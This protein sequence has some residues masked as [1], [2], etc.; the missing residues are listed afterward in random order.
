MKRLT[1]VWS[2]TLQRLASDAHQADANVV[3]PLDHG[4]AGKLWSW[5]V[6]TGKLSRNS[7]GRDGY[8]VHVE[9]TYRGSYFVIEDRKTFER[10]HHESVPAGY[11]FVLIA[12]YL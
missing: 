7:E 4:S 5:A 8:G 3:K 12:S 6:S 1:S 9:F 10:D 2:R 11:D